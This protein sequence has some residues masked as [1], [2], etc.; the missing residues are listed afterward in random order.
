MPI[1]ASAA[2]TVAMLAATCNDILQ[3]PLGPVM[4]VASRSGSC[5]FGCC[6]SSPLQGHLTAA[7]LL[8]LY[9][10]AD[11]TL[12]LGRRLAGGENVAHRTAFLS[13]RHRPRLD[14]RS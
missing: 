1:T 4:L 9:D 12:T 13:A 3:L 11:A 8:P 6:S 7:L 14:H 5:F 2:A 10:L